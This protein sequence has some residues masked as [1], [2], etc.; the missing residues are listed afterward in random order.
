MIEARD[1]ASF[2]G[3]IL[4]VQ[5]TDPQDYGRLIIEKRFREEHPRIKDIVE[6]EQLKRLRRRIK[7]RVSAV[8]AVNAGA[9]VFEL[10]PLERALK[11]VLKKKSGSF[12]VAHGQTPEWYL[13]DVVKVQNRGGAAVRAFMTEDQIS[14]V[15]FNHVEAVKRFEM[16]IG[17]LTLSADL[18]RN[19]A[20]AV[21]QGAWRDAVKAARAEIGLLEGAFNFPGGTGYVIRESVDDSPGG[22]YCDTIRVDEEETWFLIGDVQGSGI[23]VAHK[24][25]V[26]LTAF[27]TLT[28]DSSSLAHVLG[29]LRNIC[30]ERNLGGE[31][32]SFAVSVPDP[33]A[34]TRSG[35]KVL[36]CGGQ[37]LLV[38]RPRGQIEVWPRE[39]HD[40]AN[41]GWMS[42]PIKSFS[43]EDVGFLGNE[44][45]IVGYTDGIADATDSEGREFGVEGI[46][47]A[48]ATPKLRREG[49]PKEIAEAIQAAL[50]RHTGGRFRDDWTVMVIRMEERHRIARGNADH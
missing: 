34:G 36:A 22:D 29:R 24:M 31:A 27:K 13:T 47:G 7:R 25:V 8:D 32:I 38:A 1:R 16:S 23:K 49:T 2:P 4:G 30:R 45:L 19:A 48:I 14:T 11:A 17:N 26:V 46:Q 40:W 3:M 44:D 9:F 28:Q 42:A 50:V 43:A 39:E 37:R 21:R 12:R 6:K 15:G 5:R 18:A 41:M 10:K 20:D 35:L 33:K